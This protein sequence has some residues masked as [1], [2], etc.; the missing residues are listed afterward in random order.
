LDTA[1][2][3]RGSLIAS[4]F[5]QQILFVKQWIIAPACDAT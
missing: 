1:H 2:L 4:P 5:L 3:T